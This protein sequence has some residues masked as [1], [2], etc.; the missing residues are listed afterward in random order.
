MSTVNFYRCE[1]CGN[2][3]ALIELG[4][5]TLSCCGQAMTKLVA[6]STEAAQE[7]HIPIVTREDG[8]IKVEVGSTLHPMLPEHYI[9][10]IAFVAEDKVQFKFLKPGEE[11]IA[12]FD[13]SE[14]GM[15]YAYCNL[16]G[17]WDAELALE[18]EFTIAN[19]SACSAEYSD[20]CIIPDH[21]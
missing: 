11:P 12:E 10:W 3:V 19:E 16:H 7:K 8:K 2:I 14:S 1:K 6:N 18:E 15:V 9:Q 5:G 21:N 20:G 4:G 13:E 17:L